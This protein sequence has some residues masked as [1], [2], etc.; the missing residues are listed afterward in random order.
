MLNKKK[1]PLSNQNS[2]TELNGLIIMN[3][4]LI[5]LIESPRRQD[6]RVRQ[7]HALSRVQGQLRRHAGRQGVQ[8]GERHQ[9]RARLQG[10]RAGGDE[11]EADR[12]HRDGG[13]EDRLRG[14]HR[15]AQRRYAG[16]HLRRVADRQD[17]RA[18]GVPAA[19]QPREDD[20]SPH[21]E[22]LDAPAPRPRAG[23]SLRQRRE[24]HEVLLLFIFS[25][26]NFP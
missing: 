13:E 2:L 18:D 20:L 12:H 8:L 1:E 10:G 15:R 4:F 11:E 14:L 22:R 26:N 17:D 19:Q 25:V 3:L 21:G 23:A 6:G 7:E 9:G 5:L 24:A 16:L